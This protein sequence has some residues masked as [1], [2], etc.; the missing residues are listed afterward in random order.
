LTPGVRS[1]QVRK[2]TVA[3][4][5]SLLAA[6]VLGG[7]VAVGVGALLDEDGDRAAAT[8]TVTTASGSG[9]AGGGGGLSAGEVY[10][11]AASAV[12][13]I[14]SGNATG[15]GFVIDSDGHVVTNEHVVDQAETAQVSFAEGGE[16][17]ARVIAT[18]R[19]TDLAVLEVDLEGHGVDPLALDSSANV[20][21]GDQ[22]YA[23]GNPFGLERSLTAGIVS[24]VGRQI[25]APNGFTIDDAIQ[26]D[27]PVNQGNSGGPLLDAAGDVIGVVSQIASETGGNV[28]IGY[29][30][31]S[32]TVRTV[33]DG[34]L[35]DGEIR[36]AYLGVRLA[37]VDGGVRL[38]EVIEGEP[39]DD[40]EL[41]AGDVVLE[42]GGKPVATAADIQGAVAARKPG[43]ELE[44]QIRRGGNERTVTV[45]LGTR[46][47]AVQ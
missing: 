12:V 39:A 32:D 24:A 6:A 34:L 2:A 33:V 37:E 26:T 47:P 13:E 15:T 25:Q 35:R 44:L 38:A 28:G 21:V 31:P 17:R 41:R 7:L 14:Q 20:K 3:R 27:A 42:A 40:A 23:I 11:R 30:V 43:D 45:K 18:D 16:E 1:I 29:A 8:A 10:S 4:T 46:P 5:A 19:S 22:V 9:S 36:R